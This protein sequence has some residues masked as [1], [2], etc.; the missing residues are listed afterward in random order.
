MQA[1]PAPGPDGQPAER[2][3][4]PAFHAWSEVRKQIHETVFASYCGKTIVGNPCRQAAFRRSFCTQTAMSGLLSYILSVPGR[5]PHRMLISRSTGK[6]LQSDFNMAYDANNLIGRQTDVV[7]FRLSRNMTRYIGDIMI[8]GELALR[9]GGSVVGGLWPERWAHVA[10]PFVTAVA[11]TAQAATGK[12]SNFESVLQVFFRDEI[13]AMNTHRQYLSI[14]AVLSGLQ[15]PIPQ[16]KHTEL[17]AAVLANTRVRV[18]SWWPAW[19]P[20]LRP[21]LHPSPCRR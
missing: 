4:D 13:L 21:L 5:T 17:E 7:P 11:A 2:T 12:D 8:E 19:R 9:A 15:Q 20:G 3:P 14:K 1:P 6:V 16:A 18:Y 10:G